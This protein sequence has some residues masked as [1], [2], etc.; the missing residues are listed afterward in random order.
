MAFYGTGTNLRGKIFFLDNF[1]SSICSGLCEKSVLKLHSRCPEKFPRN[2]SFLKNFFL[3]KH[4]LGLWARNLRSFSQNISAGLSR[5]YYR[6]PG[7]KFEGKFCWK[8]NFFQ[9]FRNFEQNYFRPLMKVFQQ[10]CQSYILAIQRQCPVETCFFLF[11]SKISFGRW[12]KSFRIFSNFFLQVCHHNSLRVQINFPREIIFS[13]KI[14]KKWIGNF[15]ENLS[16]FWP[17]LH[18]M[19]VKAAF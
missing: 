2:L 6:Y 17:E 7:A 9:C 3:S 8:K 11:F 19:V 13:I 16:D 5:L 12:A 18:S 10:S 1:F 14:L 15:S 4:F